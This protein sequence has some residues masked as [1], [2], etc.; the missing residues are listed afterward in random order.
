MSIPKRLRRTVSIICSDLYLGFINAA[1]EVFGKQI[2][3]V[4]DRFH[5]AKLYREGLDSLRKKEMKRLKDTLSEKQYK[6]LKN[7]MWILRKQ[8]SQLS[9]DEKRILKKVF[10]Y[11]PKLKEAY[12]LMNKLTDI[13]NGHFTKGQAKRKIKGWM[14]QIKNKEVA[15]FKKFLNTLNNNMEEIT[16][17]FINRNNSGF[18]E[19]LNTKIKVIKRRCYGITNIQHLFQRIFLDFEGYKVFKYQ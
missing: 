8:N 18:V 19:G 16:N 11:S 13:F 14:K 6:G 12:H 15:C 2:T 7:I 3:V 9:S 4:A 17:Y 5:V 10:K 1:K